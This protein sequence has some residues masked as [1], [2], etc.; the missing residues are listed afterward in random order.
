MISTELSYC[1]GDLDAVNPYSTQRVEAAFNEFRTD[2]LKSGSAFTLGDALAD[3]VQRIRSVLPKSTAA[4]S[5]LRRLNKRFGL[6][7][8]SNV[9]AFDDLFTAAADAVAGI[10][11]GYGAAT[12]SGPPKATLTTIHSAI[13]VHGLG[14][15]PG[16]SA[17]CPQGRPG[18]PS[19]AVALRVQTKVL[20]FDACRAI[21][22][23]FFH[24][25]VCHVFQG[26]APAGGAPPAEKD[27]FAEGWMDA[28][29]ITVHS[30]VMNGD[31]P[32]RNFRRLF[33]DPPGYLAGGLALHRLRISSTDD[34]DSIYRQQGAG[35]FEALRNVLTGLHKDPRTALDRTI[36]VSL[37]LNASN[38][39]IA[40]RNRLTRL[41]RL[42]SPQIA[43]S[44]YRRALEQA[45]LAYLPSGNLAP[46]AT[47]ANH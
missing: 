45:L 29:A 8:I 11:A 10:Y 34:A 9:D 6:A 21:P 13:A 31:G 18:A 43:R 41:V 36:E 32:A 23:L 26:N 25:L 22:Y 19:K 3:L 37:R 28:V 7:A 15:G 16:I 44:Q 35:A 27:A 24:E 20:D 12:A 40:A 46:L 33:D 42:S 39:P 14:P 38:L 47:F 4:T 2:I 17:S 5:F 30:Q 1:R